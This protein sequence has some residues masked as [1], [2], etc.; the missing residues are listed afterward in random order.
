MVIVLGEGDH[1]ALAGDLQAA[2]ARH[3]DVRTFE[4]GQQAAVVSEHGH[5]EPVSMRVSYEDVPGI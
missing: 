5:V 3:L 2:A 4:L 1:I